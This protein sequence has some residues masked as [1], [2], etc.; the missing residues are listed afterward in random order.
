VGANDTCTTAAPASPS[1]QPRPRR[2]KREETM[3][4]PTKKPYHPPTLRFERAF[5]TLALTCGKVQTTQSGC[6]QN[7]KTSW[8]ITGLPPAWTP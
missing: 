7:R 6:H 5:E 1:R 3:S 2:R 8:L 4:Q